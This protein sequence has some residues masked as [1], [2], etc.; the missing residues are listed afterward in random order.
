MGNDERLGAILADAQ[1]RANERAARLEAELEAL[2]NA[3]RSESDDD[4]HDPE[5]V[6]L[7]SEWSRLA[8]LLEAANNEVRQCEDAVQRLETGGYGVCATCGEPIPIER[9]EA[10]P[11]A[12]QC[13]PC[14]SRR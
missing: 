14:A 9:L 4:E 6:T 8:G 1:Q 2:T 3:R 5:G 7:S 10:R 13:V 12:K 11:F